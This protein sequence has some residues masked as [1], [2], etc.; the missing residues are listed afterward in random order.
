M[1]P[2]FLRALPVVLVASILGASNGRAQARDGDASRLRW[3][4]GCWQQRSGALLIEEQWLAPRAGVLLGLSR[5]TRGDSLVGYEYM[6]IF[7]RGDTLRF[8]AQ[9][10]GQPPVEFVARVATAREVVF[11]NTANDFPQRVR[12]RAVGADSLRARIEGAGGGEVRGLDFPFARVAC[13][14]GRAPR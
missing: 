1:H 10:S 9:P 14:P 8:A 3:L 5:T 6:R 4:A 13:T 12:Y 11:E 7:A 2:H